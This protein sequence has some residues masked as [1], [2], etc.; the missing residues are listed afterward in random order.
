MARRGDGL[1]QMCPRACAMVKAIIP[2]NENVPDS[3]SHG[4]LASN[5][6]SPESLSNIP[7]LTFTAFIVNGSKGRWAPTNVPPGVC[8]RKGNHPHKRKRPRLIESRDAR[9][10]QA[11]PRKL[12]QHPQSNFHRLY[13]E[14]PEAAM[15]SHKCAPGVCDRKGNH[16][17]NHQGNHPHK[18]KRPRLIESWDARF[19]Q[20]LPRKLV[21]HHHSNCRRI[22]W[23]W[24]G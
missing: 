9:F 18:R 23:E 22:F 12:V 5:R 2:T 19:E 11:L 3:L 17:G 21:Q 24:P 13:C 7:T 4:T 14:W 8:D 20:A 16:Q 1:P 6:P 15:G 10:E